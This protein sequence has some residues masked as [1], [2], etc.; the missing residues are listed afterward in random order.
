MG[1]LSTLLICGYHLPPL[2][3]PSAPPSPPICLL[4]TLVALS[5]ILW[6][7]ILAGR[8][9]ESVCLAGGQVHPDHGSVPAGRHLAARDTPSGR[10]LGAT[11]VIAANEVSLCTVPLFM[12]R[13]RGR[14]SGRRPG[15]MEGNC[16]ADKRK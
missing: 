10:R 13:V 16:L 11:G 5:D 4:F 3:R 7:L 6:R 9:W 15:S 8:R 14:G 2:I 12:V 1:H